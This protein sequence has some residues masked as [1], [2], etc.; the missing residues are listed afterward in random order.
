MT[1]NIEVLRVRL[2]TDGSSFNLK[3][4]NSIG[5]RPV[6]KMGTKNRSFLGTLKFFRIFIKDFSS[7]AASLTDLT[8][9]K[10][11]LRS[12]T[13][14]AIVQFNT[15]AITFFFAHHAALGLVNSILMSYQ[16]LSVHH[17]G[18]SDSA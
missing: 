16:N 12:R 15:K 14:P 11:V 13:V 10:S 3:R 18:H 8:G 6:S 1:T 5:E 9:K 4:Q 17:G 2:R 7:L